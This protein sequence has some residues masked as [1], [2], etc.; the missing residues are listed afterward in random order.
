MSP[1]G[2]GAILMVRMCFAGLACVSLWI[3]P[4]PDNAKTSKGPPPRF[5][6]VMDMDRDT[7]ELKEARDDSTGTMK[8]TL[9]SIQIY[10][11]SGNKLT[12]D[13]FQ[14]KIKIG[15]IVLVAEGENKVDATYLRVL[16]NDTV[17]LG[18]VV[19]ARPTWTMDLKMIKPFAG[20]LAGRILGAEFNPDAIK[21]QNTGLNLRS[22]KDMIHIFLT[23]KPGR[24]VYEFNGDDPQKGRPAIHIH[25]N[26][27]KPPESRLTP[28]GM[29][30][31]WNLARK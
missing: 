13:D 20:P 12:V 16:R 26:S 22:G 25:I 15:S 6:E 24:D 7:V 9:N 2:K 30:C 19:K 17:I 21:L 28:R 3:A 23:I 27:T 10:D 11:A 8:V 18:G 4:G 5:F 31:A 1:F 29:P 14:K